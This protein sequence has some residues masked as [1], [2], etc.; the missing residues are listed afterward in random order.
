M[1]T[2]QQFKKAICGPPSNCTT[3]SYGFTPRL[4]GRDSEEW[5]AN[6]A[7]PYTKRPET[8]GDSH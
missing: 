5:H 2:M 7:W 1:S 6:G 4:D 3:E 8:Q